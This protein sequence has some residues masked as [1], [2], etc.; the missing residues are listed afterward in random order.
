[1]HFTID[2]ADLLMALRR[3]GQ[4]SGRNKTIPILG[5]VVLRA[6]G[7]GLTVASTD[8]DHW[9]SLQVPAALAAPGDIAVSGPL[10]TKAV[11][12][13][14]A[15]NIEV[16]LDNGML[17]VGAGRTK[18]RFA[19]LDVRDF[20]ATDPVKGSALTVTAGELRR[21]AEVTTWAASAEETR[22]YLRVTCLRPTEG[23]LLAWATD[24]HAMTRTG[25]ACAGD[26]PA[27]DVMLPTTAWVPLRSI[28]D[29]V[30][31]EDE[32]TVT[33]SAN[34]VAFKAGP[35]R[36]RCKLV[37]GSFPHNSAVIVDH[38]LAGKHATE[39][40][41]DAMLAALRRVRVA[42][43]DKINTTRLTI[44]PDGI[45][46]RAAGGNGAEAEDAIE[47]SG[48]AE[49]VIGFA[50]PLLLD[51]LGSMPVGRVAM[52]LSDPTGPAALWPSGTGPD[53]APQVA[54][55]MPCKL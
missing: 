31:D 45:G 42:A 9:S 21:I 16:C 6:A 24:G 55:V 8:M 23:K 22:Y 38:A 4:L 18:L 28:L 35:A 37:K 10:L 12:E 1:M 47:A 11:S 40:D 15:G 46:L 43:T 49:I 5:C 13:L 33:L 34:A 44:A 41:R 3:G 20:P 29:G 7:N 26:V 48:N 14:T 32:V 17:R 2:R 51:A 39:F 50:A 53:E 52:R 25:V 36:F 54:L 27:H 19:T 30:G